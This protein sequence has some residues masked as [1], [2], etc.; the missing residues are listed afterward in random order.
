MLCLWPLSVQCLLGR[1]GGFARFAV[2]RFCAP[3]PP[4]FLCGTPPS[5]FSGKPLLFLSLCGTPL[6]SQNASLLFAP[7]K[8]GLWHGLPQC[9]GEKSVW[10]FSADSRSF[11]HSFDFTVFSRW[12]N[13]RRAW[14]VL[15]TS[16]FSVHGFGTFG[17]KAGRTWTKRSKDSM[18]RRFQSTFKG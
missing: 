10:S 14:Q 2:T 18:C 3:L 8:I 15:L 4:T 1:V 17:N 6:V 5:G 9:L 11:L 16:V 12:R 7:Q 13:F